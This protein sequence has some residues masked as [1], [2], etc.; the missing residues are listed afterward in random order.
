MTNT[1]GNQPRLIRDV[2]STLRRIVKRLGN[3]EEGDVLND[4]SKAL[5][6]GDYGCA[7]S[8]IGMCCR[9]SLN[10]NQGEA[11]Q[12]KI[13]IR[14]LL[15]MR[16]Y[17]IHPFVID[18]IYWLVLVPFDYKIKFAVWLCNRLQDT[19]LVYSTLYAQRKNDYQILYIERLGPSPII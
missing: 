18:L 6:R 14:L 17:W 15:K 16:F 19:P 5:R 2:Q 7:I 13:I 11:N 1:F 4:A 12:L 9:Q 10:L 3:C 8:Y